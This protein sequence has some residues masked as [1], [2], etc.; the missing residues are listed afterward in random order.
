MFDLAKDGV[1]YKDLREGNK[2]AVLDFLWK[3]ISAKKMVFARFLMMFAV[4]ATEKG[5]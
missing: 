5:S 1:N 4:S 3:T 2:E